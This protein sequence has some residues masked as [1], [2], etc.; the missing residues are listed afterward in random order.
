VP[1]RLVGREGGRS[2]IR[3]EGHEGIYPARDNDAIGLGDS[4]VAALRPEKIELLAPDSR[5]N[6]YAGVFEGRVSE[7]IFTGE[8]ISVF[9]DTACGALT[10]STQNRPGDGLAVAAGENVKVGWHA[11]DMLVFPLP[12]NIPH[13]A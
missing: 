12:M 11:A 6:G 5:A 13:K 3:L 9:L 8:K 2:L 1:G 4:I 10:V 7:V